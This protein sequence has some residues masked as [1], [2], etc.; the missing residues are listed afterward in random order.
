MFYAEQYGPTQEDD[1]LY[2]F[3]SENDRDKFLEADIRDRTKITL[4]E[5]RLFYGREGVLIAQKLEEFGP[6]A[7][8]DHEYMVWDAI[9]I[10]NMKFDD[11]LGVYVTRPYKGA[12]DV[13]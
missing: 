13:D 5:A 7:D 2:A 6:D 8:V 4:D 12:F 1:I 11:C 10:T 9:G 3:K